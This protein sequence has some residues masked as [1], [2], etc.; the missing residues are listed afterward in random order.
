M[1]LEICKIKDDS[2]NN[3]KLILEFY[4]NEEKTKEH[5]LCQLSAREDAIYEVMKLKFP[6]AILL[7][8]NNAIKSVNI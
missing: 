6:N 7:V 8:K 1:D 3:A 2:Q 4:L 5:F